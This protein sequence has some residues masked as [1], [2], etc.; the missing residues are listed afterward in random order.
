MFIHRSFF[1]QA[2]FDNPDNP[3]ASTYAPS[4]LSAYRSASGAIKA[5]AYH[6]ERFP[7]LLPRVWSVWTS[8]EQRMSITGLSTLTQLFPLVLVFPAAVGGLSCIFYVVTYN[9]FR[10]SS[11]AL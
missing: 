2:V 9:S 7:G 8:R 11:A 1:T 4:F 5:T 3:L 6:F 10:L